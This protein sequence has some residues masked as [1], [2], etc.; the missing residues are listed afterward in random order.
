LEFSSKK[1]GTFMFIPVV[2]APPSP[3]AEELG[4]RIADLVQE[5]E[6]ANHPLSNL[7]LSQAL[8][9]ARGKVRPDARPGA[10]VALVA[11]LLGLLLAVGLGV[12][13]SQRNSPGMF[14]GIPWIAVSIGVLLV[15][16]AGVAISRRL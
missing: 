16:L 15:V 10:Q 7:E 12:F 8:Q 9:L 2:Q 1:K 13:V 11:G 3:R 14:E 4:R 5:Y 6:S